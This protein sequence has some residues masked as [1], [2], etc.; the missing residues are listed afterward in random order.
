MSSSP[1][2]EEE[3]YQGQNIVV[4]VRVRPLSNKEISSGQKNCVSSDENNVSI[5]K[6]GDI[7][8]YLKSQINDTI[9]TFTFD[10]V[11]D[12]AASQRDIYHKTIQRFVPKI[13]LGQH[14]TIF[15]YGA[16][17]A[18]KTHTMFGDIEGNDFSLDSNSGI[19]VK[20]VRD[21]LE[22]TEQRR[23]FAKEGEVWITSF[24]FMEVYN[25]QV[26][27][28]LQY[29][30]KN[31]SI[32]EDADKGIVQVTG[33]SETV[34]QSPEHFID[35][36][37]HGQKYRKMEPTQA[38]VVSSRSHAILQVI[39]RC[40]QRNKYGKETLT[41]SKLSLID[42]A[43]SERASRTGNTGLRQQEG[44]NINKSLLALSNCINALAENCSLPSGSPKRTNVKFR[45]SKL[46]HLL[47]SSLEGNSYLIMLANISPSDLTYEDS[48]KT[49]SY[50]KRAKVIMVNPTVRANL[51]ESTSLE[52]EIQLRAENELL[53][54][55]LDEQ[56]NEL[57]VLRA[58][59]EQLQRL[60]RSQE[61]KITHE[62]E[63]MT[64]ELKEQP[65]LH[66]VSCEAMVFPEVFEVSCQAMAVDFAAEEVAC[67]ANLR[68]ET[69]E[70]SCQTT[71]VS[72]KEMECQTTDDL[73]PVRTIIRSAPTAVSIEIQTDPISE[74]SSARQ[75][76]TSRTFQRHYSEDD[77]DLDINQIYFVNELRK[78]KK[79][80]KK[81]RYDPILM[82]YHSMDSIL[83]SYV[84]VGQEH[85][86]KQHQ[87]V[88]EEESLCTVKEKIQ[89]FE[90]KGGSSG[91]GRSS[92]RMK[93]TPQIRQGEA[94]A[95]LLDEE[96]SQENSDRDEFAQL[97]IVE[98]DNRSSSSGLSLTTDL[99]AS[100]SAQHHR[101]F[102]SITS[103]MDRTVN[104]LD[105]GHNSSKGNA[106]ADVPV[107]K[108]ISFLEKQLSRSDS[109]QSLST[110]SE[111]AKGNGNI[112]S[113]T[114]DAMSQQNISLISVVHLSKAPTKEDRIPASRRKS[115][116]L[117][118]LCG[119][120]SDA[121]N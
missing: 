95:G 33:L 87:Q 32:R 94:S 110:L 90:R 121:L 117:Y 118:F 80:G 106:V 103:E 89:H 85:E 67:Q 37:R 105:D 114:V 47:K 1:N 19:I 36:V 96:D 93:I 29:T 68:E 84:I 50:A 99:I 48:L 21:L 116:W 41:E 63:T 20:S 62:I 112:S 49:L 78:L 58:D 16:T 65:V 31:L 70:F 101:S 88:C 45:D 26:Y 53:Q 39:V 76:P 17:G 71:I 73:I 109:E 79:S 61:E 97:V 75:R 6:A 107:R 56:D 83:P 115:F 5:R 9:N 34:I 69:A 2:N 7:N 35:L 52:R 60:L 86:N 59:M 64:E 66:S 43:G 24:C 54:K 81:L 23:Q 14:V 8:G 82:K 72:T 12:E 46:T 3:E 77:C 120:N 108:Q 40:L 11:F 25:E 22:Q 18:G 51:L 91:E 44:A 38:N 113:K 102:E 104:L 55:R 15:A 119:G 4:A 42:L 98:E 13:H 27:D 100:P 57:A 28:L 111:E 92:L 10:H 74:D 30:G